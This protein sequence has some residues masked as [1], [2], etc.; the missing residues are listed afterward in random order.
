[1]EDPLW[2][3]YI[4]TIELANSIFQA[5][6]TKDAASAPRESVRLTPA[7]RHCDGRGFRL[8][9]N[10]VASWCT[11]ETAWAVKAKMSTFVEEWNQRVE[12]GQ[13]GSAPAP[14]PVVDALPRPAIP[15]ARYL[16][17]QYTGAATHAET[18][19]PMCEE[20]G[21]PFGP[22]RCGTCGEHLICT[23]CDPQAS[24]GSSS[25]DVPDE[26]KLG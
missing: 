15:D 24:L 19:E 11:C 2:Y 16:E 23:S 4:K 17:P 21:R 10:R 13:F 25:Q 22:P 12:F 3:A 5:I 6:Q 14:Q 18:D 1:M 20:C 9:G 26:E 8:D 7:C